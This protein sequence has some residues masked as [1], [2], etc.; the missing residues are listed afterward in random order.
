MQNKQVEKEYN[1]KLTAKEAD[2]AVQILGQAAFE[3]VEHIIPK[4]KSQFAAQKL[5]ES[6]PPEKDKEE[7]AN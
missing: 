2:V 1:F 5:L 7:K 3:V 4:M 6:N